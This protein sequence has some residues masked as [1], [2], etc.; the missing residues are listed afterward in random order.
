[1]NCD[2]NL[3]CIVKIGRGLHVQQKTL[4]ADV[5]HN[6]RAFQINS[7]CVIVK[8]SCIF[9]EKSTSNTVVCCWIY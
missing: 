9:H 2:S 6:S 7:F 5:Q 1:M 8:R 4:S 3:A